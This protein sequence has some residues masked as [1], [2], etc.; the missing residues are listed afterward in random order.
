MVVGLEFQ[1]RRIQ[2]GFNFSLENFFNVG[3]R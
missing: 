1:L 2:S 3:W